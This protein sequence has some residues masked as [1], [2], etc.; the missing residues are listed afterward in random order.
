MKF[1]FRLFYLTLLN[2]I[3]FT[4]INSFYKV[5]II[6]SAFLTSIFLKQFLTFKKIE[7]QNFLFDI[8]F[9][10]SFLILFSEENLLLD[11]ILFIILMI[12]F[13]KLPFSFYSYYPIPIFVFIVFITLQYF[14]KINQKFFEILPLFIVLSI[15]YIFLSFQNFILILFRI[16]FIIITFYI[17]NLPEFIK[18]ISLITGFYFFIFVFPFQ[19]IKLKRREYLLKIFIITF[20]HLI[21]FSLFNFY[22]SKIESHY[23]FSIIIILYLFF[24]FIFYILKNRLLNK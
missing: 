4:Y 10:F 21:L 7:I 3:V 22:S 23:Y 2:L 19:L 5:V 20:E 14:L 1:L 17:L 8:S 15:P 9:L 6:G 11:L 18:N 13:F 24:D 16:I 12:L